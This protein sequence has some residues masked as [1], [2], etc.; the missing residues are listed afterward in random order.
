[1][2]LRLKMGIMLFRKE[3]PLN[4]QTLPPDIKKNIA[5]D[6]PAKAA[7]IP[8]HE[9]PSSAKALLGISIR[10]RVSL[11]FGILLTIGAAVGMFSRYG[12]KAISAMRVYTLTEGLWMKAQKEAVLSLVTFSLSHKERDF[13]NFQN[14]LETAAENIKL[15]VE[16]GQEGPFR[17]SKSFDKAVNIWNKS[18]SLNAELKKAGLLV[19]EAVSSS[20]TS[21]EEILSLLDKVALIHGKL[22]VLE[23]DFS[24]V[25]GEAAGQTRKTLVMLIFSVAAIAL[26]V[27]ILLVMFLNKLV[28]ARAKVNDIVRVGTIA[29]RGDFTARVEVGSK[30][31]L[32]Q[33][34]VIF[35]EIIES[36][37]GII[38]KIRHA[39]FQ[40]SSSSAR[41]RTATEKQASGAHEQSVAV[42]EI[43]VT[44]KE[45][46]TAASGIAGNADKVS[47]IADQTSARMQEVN[48]K[49]EEASKK[50]LSLGEKSQAISEIIRLIE[51][52]ADQTNL[53]ALNAAIEAARAGEAGSGF[54]VV[55]QEVSLLAKRASR[56]TE[57]IRQ[58]ITQI[59]AETNAT[60]VTIS[61]LAE[62]VSKS[63]DLIKEAT[64]LAK[65]ISFATGQQ[66]NAS[67]Q[68][69]E[70]MNNIHGITRQF[71]A[72][73]NHVVASMQELDHLSQDLKTTIGKFKIAAELDAEP[74]APAPPPIEAL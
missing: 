69:V 28:A 52:I 35:N 10:K 6:N 55:A 33:L 68:V 66:K 5:K 2:Q 13:Q 41:I 37:G 39:G 27:T 70:T 21:R 11:L 20:T 53:L 50:I 4:N 51:M 38:K 14:L 36:L 19:R 72:T 42:D 62:W 30:N 45:L 3:T 48:L 7:V 8:P 59:Q 24:S 23:D 29:S 47:K 54:A 18:G 16:V 65:E 44:M 63:L 57:E 58:L 73:T 26:T 74:A 64:K 49:A 22:L 40:I 31:E 56:S 34:S 71:A 32:S 12:L 9:D 67:Q 25:M 15:M 61:N 43:A 17:N 1:M 46:A 60:I